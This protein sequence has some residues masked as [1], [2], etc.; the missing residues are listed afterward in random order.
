M[1]D[2]AL[3]LAGRSPE[4]PHKY[5][6]MPICDHASL[7]AV[8][9]YLIGTCLLG[10]AVAGVLERSNV[11]CLYRSLT[12]ALLLPFLALVLY[13]RDRAGW[14]AP[15]LNLVDVLGLGLIALGLEVY[16]RQLEPDNE[17]VTQW[18]GT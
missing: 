10:F 16:Q 12:A 7:P 9:A 18:D 14:F 17:L 6:V 1:W 8:C 11:R 13:S 5:P 2:L 15:A 3:C 4:D